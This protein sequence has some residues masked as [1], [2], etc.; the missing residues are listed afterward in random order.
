MDVI[1]ATL[2][3]LVA[4]VAQWWLLIAL[5]VGVF[6]VGRVLNPSTAEGGRFAAVDGLRTRPT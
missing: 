4:F 1:G 5:L 6:Y 2:D 3:H